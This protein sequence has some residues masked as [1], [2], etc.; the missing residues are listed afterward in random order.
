[1]SIPFSAAA[2]AA[3]AA[4]RRRD[5]QEEEDMTGYSTDDLSGWEFKIVRSAFGAFRNPDKVR[6]LLEEESRAG[7]ELL[8]KFDDQRI[9]LK[10]K[11]EKRK[12]DSTLGYDAYRT[13]YGAP[14][15][16]IA[17]IVLVAIAVGVLVALLAARH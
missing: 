11:V 10:R 16:T 6:R 1:M 8:E 17:I 9:R 2:G 14:E 4:K 13:S 3:A 12:N 7:W 15:Y 5:Q